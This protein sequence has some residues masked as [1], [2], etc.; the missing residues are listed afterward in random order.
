MRN[1]ATGR[2]NLVRFVVLGGLLAFFLLAALPH[3]VASAAP[4]PAEV[5][6][7]VFTLFKPKE[8]QCAGASVTVTTSG[9][10]RTLPSDATW[11]IALAPGG[12]AL[13]EDANAK[14]AVF[15]GNSI[16][17]DGPAVT[18]SVAGRK[19]RLTREFS[20]RLR[21]TSDG[22]RLVIV[23][24]Q[25]LEDAVGVIT[26]SE[27]VGNDNPEAIKAMAV[28]ARSY[29]AANLKRHAR[30]GFDLCDSTHCQ[31]YYGVATS[32]FEEAFDDA[33][34][35]F[36]A[37]ALTADAARATRGELLLNGAGR[38]LAAFTTAC[39]GGRTISPASAFGGTSRVSGERGVACDWCRDAKFYRWERSVDRGRLLA[40]F[41]SEWGA[42]IP[43]GLA[44]HVA[45]RTPDG[46]VA[47]L[48]LSDGHR[49]VTIPNGRF[50]HLVGRAIGWNTVL[51]NLYDLET[52]GDTLV[53]RG[54]GFGH[55]VGLCVAGATAQ[56]RAGRSYRE[57]LKYYFPDFEPSKR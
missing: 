47:S 26:N 12:V 53:F 43:D 42:A 35:E 6:I 15:V 23:L 10:A 41:K 17:L 37:S 40:A 20:G 51:S 7:G 28:V 46:A 3:R 16:E 13:F 29:L 33:P 8:I 57:I 2:G 30:E 1:T 32:V 9:A 19:T 39:C 18:L 21:V 22:T 44:L 45:A 52:R 24:T 34:R 4:L 11:R 5:R 38:P 36:A 50:R 54:R 27:L 31:L 25:P 55:Q 56:A 48:A 49:T 14:T